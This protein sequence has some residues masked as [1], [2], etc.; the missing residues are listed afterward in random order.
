MA[1]CIKVSPKVQFAV[2][3]SINDDAGIAR[4][5][6]FRLT[7]TRMSADEFHEATRDLQGVKTVD[8]MV[9]LVLDWDGVKDPSGK[10]V[11]FAEAA[12]RELFR[13]PGLANLAFVAYASESGAKA[14]N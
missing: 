2:K 4:P 8:F 7:C 14:K 13:I 3:G 11:P 9:P 1:I 6:D 5:F 10:S 12:L